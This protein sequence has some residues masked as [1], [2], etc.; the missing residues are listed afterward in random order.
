FLK[1]GDPGETYTGT[2]TGTTS[3]GGVFV[4]LD[5]YLVDGMVRPDDMPGQGR[6]AGAWKQ[7]R[8]SGRL[9]APGS[10][11][12]IGIGDRAEVQIGLIDLHAREMDLVP[13]SFDPVTG[14]DQQE[15]ERKRSWRT[16]DRPGR[17][18][19]GGKPRKG[20]RKGYKMGRRGRRSS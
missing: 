5:K 9:F 7:D 4:T 8:L 1:A 15:D 20:K 10:G 6:G 18:D 11:A 17:R 3:G 2:I 14:P 12:S 13:V 16:A 19:R